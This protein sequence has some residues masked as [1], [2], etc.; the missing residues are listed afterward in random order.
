MIFC[1]VLKTL[2]LVYNTVKYHKSPCVPKP[3]IFNSTDE[4]YSKGSI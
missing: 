3:H 4:K 2:I 1:L